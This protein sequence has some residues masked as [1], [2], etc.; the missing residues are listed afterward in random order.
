MPPWMKSDFYSILSQL[1]QIIEYFSKAAN[2]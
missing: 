1:T 2:S